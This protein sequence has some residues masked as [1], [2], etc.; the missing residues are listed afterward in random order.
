MCA[1]A[2]LIGLDI[3][4]SALKAVAFDERGRTAAERTAV[5]ATQYPG[6]GQAEQ[7]PEDW[8]NAACRCLRGLFDDGGVDP[9]QVAAVGVDGMSWSFAALGRDGT[10]LC[11]TPIWMDTRAQAQCAALERT[12]GAG[13]LL[14]LSG[15]TLRPNFSLPK[16]LWLREQA[17]ALADRCAVLLESNGFLVYRLTGRTSAEPTQGFGWACFDMER[18]CWDGAL[19]RD[20]GVDR[21]LPPL[22]ACDS[23]VGGVTPE[24]ACATGLLAGTPVVAGGLDTACGTLAAGVVSFG[25][26]QEQ[27]G[28]SGGIA[29]YT[30]RYAPQPPLI[31]ARHVLPEGY[32]PCP[33]TVAGAASYA[34]FEREFGAPERLLASDGQSSFAH[35]DALASAVPAGSEG[36]LFLP[37]LAGERAPIWDPDAKG[38]FFGLD[39]QKTRGHFAR[40][41]LEGVAYSLRHI[42]ETTES[43]G[44]RVDELLSVG[45]AARSPVWMQIKADVT[46][47]PLRTRRGNVGSA[48]GAAMCAGV[49]IGLY[50]DYPAAAAAVETAGT[51]Y[52]PDAAR[53]ERYN[54]YYPIY[55]S[56]YGQ[57]RES[58]K[59]LS[60]LGR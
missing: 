14:R 41:V 4:T 10:A 53:H 48:L 7:R 39:F 50:A 27:G 34:W 28:Q 17:P 5:Y 13:A 57:T 38:M 35:L 1:L 42:I 6:P 20:L 9:A 11:P 45:G 12:Y 16:W 55:K 60:G 46:G 49:G 36:L 8:W 3:G 19:A 58:M 25:Q 44:V 2:C 33:A 54:A 23:V 32:L 22:A 26:V 30:D 21:L 59:A 15:N 29:V 18:G 40:A 24:A 47:K 51:R 37:Y 52:R 56:L 43:V 31:L